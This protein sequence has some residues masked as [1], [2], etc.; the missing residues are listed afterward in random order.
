MGR[1]ALLLL[2]ALAISACGDAIQPLGVYG[3]AACSSTERGKMEAVEA[4]AQ[5]GGPDCA[6]HTP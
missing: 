4:S 1:L 6:D 5:L 3:T 2:A